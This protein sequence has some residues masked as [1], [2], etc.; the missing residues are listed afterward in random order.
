MGHA[1]REPQ[2][3]LPQRW[4]PTWPT[5][6]W[7]RRA[8]RGDRYPGSR[9]HPTIFSCWRIENRKR[10]PDDAL[11]ERLSR[12][13]GRVRVYLLFGPAEED[14]D[15]FVERFNDCLLRRAL[16]L[17]GRDDAVNSFKRMQR[18]DTDRGE[19]AAYVR[20]VLVLPGR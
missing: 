15:A 20:P 14:H 8:A 17:E 2:R 5:I 19:D 3:S 11:H 13:R 9:R 18:P 6:F 10:R 1:F 7:T 12:R 4:S 16:E